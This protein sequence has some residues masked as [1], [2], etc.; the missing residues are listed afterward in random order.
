MFEPCCTIIGSISHLWQSYF[1]KRDFNAILEGVDQRIILTAVEIFMWGASADWRVLSAGAFINWQQPASPVLSF[2]RTQNHPATPSAGAYPQ[3]TQRKEEWDVVWM[4]PNVCGVF[5]I[6]KLSWWCLQISSELHGSSLQATSLKS[7]QNHF[8]WRCHAL[9]WLI[10]KS[11][12]AAFAAWFALL[13]AKTVWCTEM[14]L[15]DF[16]ALRGDVDALGWPDNSLKT[17]RGAAFIIP[18]AAVSG[19]CK[20]NVCGRQHCIQA[21]FA[22]SRCFWSRG[23]KSIQHVRLSEVLGNWELR[24]EY[25]RI[26]IKYKVLESRS[27]IGTE[28]ENWQIKLAA[29]SVLDLARAN[30]AL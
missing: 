12:T 16:D 29:N 18:L 28:D 15:G 20:S 11:L 1:Q 24:Y 27:R 4:N 22:R 26:E 2:L 13:S 23:L 30:L 10:S 5:L 6:K 17:V 21:I 8:K 14:H 19:G 9:E 3:T 7:T 25:M